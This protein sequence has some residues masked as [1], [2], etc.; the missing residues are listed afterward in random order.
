[1]YLNVL[2]QVIVQECESL[3]AAIFSTLANPQSVAVA[4]I[5]VGWCTHLLNFHVV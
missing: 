4:V 5:H 1:M 3:N 2:M